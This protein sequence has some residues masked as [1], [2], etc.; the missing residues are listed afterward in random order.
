MGTLTRYLTS[1]FIPMHS[2]PL[3][4]CAPGPIPLPSPPLLPSITDRLSLLVSQRLLP[5]PPLRCSP[6]CLHEINPPTPSQ[7][8]LHPPTH[9]T[10]CLSLLVSQPLLPGSLLRC[11]PLCLLH[12][13][14]I[15]CQHPLQ[16]LLLPTL[17]LL[18]DYPTCEKEERMEKQKSNK[19][20]EGE[21][22]TDVSIQLPAPL[23]VLLL[24][25][26]HRIT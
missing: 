14:L 24:S 11:S 5:H 1:H 9:R 20:K 6:P 18:W 15:L 2:W 22:E 7:T 25:F 12:L 3:A 10:G 8:P 13:P 19:S 23:S 4:P 21:K 26:S 16:L 17:L